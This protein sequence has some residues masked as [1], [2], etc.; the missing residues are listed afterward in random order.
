VSAET[1]SFGRWIEDPDLSAGV[2]R[3]LVEEGRDQ[4]AILRAIPAD[5]ICRQL[6]GLRSLWS[7]EGTMRDAFLATVPERRLGLSREMVLW[8][9]DGFSARLDAEQACRRIA[10][11]LG[12]IDCLDGFVQLDAGRRRAEPLGVVLH[13]VSGNVFFGPAESVLVALCT[14]NASI[15]KCPAEGADF[16]RFFVR[17]LEHAAPELAKAV[18]MVSWAGGREDVESELG[19]LVDGVVV[20]AGPETVDAYRRRTDP[21][22]AIVE[23]GPRVSAAVISSRGLR[24][25]DA[26]A[27]ARDVAAWDQLACTA[28]Q[29]VYVEG[30]DDGRRVAESLSE[31]LGRLAAR[32][33]EG[34][35]GIDERIEV[36]RFREL[37]RFADATGLGR[38]FVPRAPGTAT[39]VFETDPAFAPSPLRRCVRVKPYRSRAELRAA[40]APTRGLLQTVGLAVAAEERTPYEDLLSSCGARRLCAIGRMNEPAAGALRD[41]AMELQRLVRWVEA[42]PLP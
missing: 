14:K 31:R 12:S 37:G 38:L 40:L 27:L 22:A 41:G 20:A 1:F 23:L 4:A 5:E 11:Q 26:D 24:S 21:R 34:E 30:G 28:A 18:A 3:R 15:L 9:L 6:G 17:S 2:L 13:V 10:D 42:E 39:V 29:C 33:P 8:A 36:A 32:L 16:C 25:L 7:R 19:R 35:V